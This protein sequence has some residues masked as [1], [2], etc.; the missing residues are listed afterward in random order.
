MLSKRLASTAAICLLLAAGTAA[1]GGD[2]D[3]AAA[4][5]KLDTD[6]LSAQEIEK[7]A[8]DA[9]AGA[10]SVKIAGSIADE[11]G[12]TSID[13][14][15]DT[16]GQCTG[17][18]GMPG[19]GSF[20]II[21]DGKASYLKPDK[22]FWKSFGGPKGEQVAELFKGRYL[23]GFE[24]DPQMKSLTTV[25]NLAELSKKITEDDGTKSKAEKGS[26]GTVNGAKTFSLKVTNSDGEQSTIHVATE[27]KFYPVRIEKTTGKDGGQIDFTEYDKPVTI[28]VPAADSVI[29]FAK[30]KQQLQ[31][32]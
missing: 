2:K 30:F 1:C 16:K 12:K 4:G 17:S 10:S 13:L 29:D 31:T 23:T 15:L 18:M 9:L 11:D 7:Q 8:K 14:S 26:A 22:E 28:K 25:C 27:G 20:E 21:S 6:K 19:M 32:A 5:P 24:G 3:T